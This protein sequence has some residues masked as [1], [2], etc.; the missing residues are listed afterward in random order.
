MKCSICGNDDERLFL[1]NKCLKCLKY[2]KK[3]SVVDENYIP[4]K[5]KG[6]YTLTKRQ[7][8]ISKQIINL[9]DNE[10]VLIN[11]VTGAGKTE[12]IY[13]LIERMVNEDKKIG[14]ASPRKDL[15][16]EL[17]ERIRSTF[18][19]CSI[20]TLYGGHNSVSNASLYI[21]TTHQV[22][23]FVDFFDCLIL[24]E[25]DAFPYYKNEVLN[26]LVKRSVKGHIVY[27]SATISKMKNVK[28][29]T[30]NRR[31]HNKDIPTPKICIRCFK[32]IF[33]Y[34]IVKKLLKKDRYILI[35]V[36]SIKVG[37]ELHK[38][39]QRYIKSISFI[40]S[41]VINR[42]SLFNDIKKYKYKII[43][44]TTIL[45]RGITLKNVSAIVYDSESAIFDESTLLQIV[46]R[47]GRKVGY[48]E[49]EIIFLSTCRKKKM[50]NVIKR[51]NE[52]NKSM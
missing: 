4:S 12:M 45:E 27:M 20:N 34:R 32:K 9:I 10:D 44:T 21:F 16:I 17:D 51:I 52:L 7:E 36:S 22:G 2:I 31:Y 46:G 13:P 48:E 1:N 50:N 3:D 24:D 6:N 14:F 23:F 30:L 47:V 35:F 39:L 49:G 28:T 43:I 26:S 19:T 25:V 37:E 40:H 15:I 29:L 8:E 41:K 33:L 11:A 18:P 5:I 42:E 38:Y